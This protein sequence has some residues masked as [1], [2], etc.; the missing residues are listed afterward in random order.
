[1][2]TKIQNRVQVSKIVKTLLVLYEAVAIHK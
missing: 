1:V 2:L